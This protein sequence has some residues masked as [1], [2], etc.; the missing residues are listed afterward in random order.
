MIGDAALTH[1]FH[2]RNSFDVGVISVKKWATEGSQSHAARHVRNKSKA[3]L[4]KPERLLPGLG[5]SSTSSFGMDETPDCAGYRNSFY[6]CDGAK[7]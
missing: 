7:I 5:V 6:C 2:A 3:S 1:N 4:A